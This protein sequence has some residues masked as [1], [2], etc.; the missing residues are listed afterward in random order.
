MKQRYIK[1]VKA[2][3]ARQ[4]GKLS[5]LP[6][7]RGKSYAW[8]LARPQ[9][10]LNE[11]FHTETDDRIVTYLQ[12]LNR[13]PEPQREA[14]LHE[15]ASSLLNSPIAYRKRNVK[16][17]DKISS[18]KES[19]RESLLNL[20]HN[21]EYDTKSFFNEATKKWLVDFFSPAER[22]QLMNWLLRMKENLDLSI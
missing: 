13:I 5:F 20:I 17:K 8:D 21:T 15:F 14:M 6:T 4:N 3:P 7:Y 19:F 10:S 1:E 12:T 22:S 16:I 9:M 18:I 2:D 11:I